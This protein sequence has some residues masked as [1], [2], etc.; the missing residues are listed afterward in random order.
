MRSWWTGVAPSMA[1]GLLVEIAAGCGAPGASPSAKPKPPTTAAEI[2]FQVPTALPPGTEGRTIAAGQ[3]LFMNSAAI[4]GN[5]LS[6]TSCHLDGGTDKQVLPL[7]GVEST[8]P[9]VVRR[10]GTVFTMAE[11][12]NGCI[13]RSLVGKELPLGST[14]L[15][16]LTAYMTWISSGYPVNPNGNVPW[17]WHAKPSPQSTPSMIAAGQKLYTH[18]C[19]Y[20][21]SAQGRRGVMMNA[22]ALWGNK[23]FGSTAGVAKLSTLAVFFKAA[24][25]A[26]PIQGY[27]PGRLTKTQSQDV[28]AYVLSKPG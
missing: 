7:V 8:F 10:T 21:H 24:M 13:L 18:V 26:A 17:V 14:R 1:V 19:I 2:G 20:C 9:I 5:N 11:R 25:P 12:L 4:S 23:S 22:P 28:A 3:A 16:E 15:T 6:C 27:T